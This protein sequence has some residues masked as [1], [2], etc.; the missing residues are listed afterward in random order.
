MFNKIINKISVLLFITTF[1]ASPMLARAQGIRVHGAVVNILYPQM[2]IEDLLV[3]IQVAEE[4]LVADYNGNW[5]D[6]LLPW[7]P[8]YSYKEISVES[9]HENYFQVESIQFT[10][11]QIGQ[12]ENT[13]KLKHRKNL[14]EEKLTEAESLKQ[15]GLFDKAIKLVNQAI[16]LNP[17]PRAYIMKVQLIHKMLRTDVPVPPEL[18]KFGEDVKHDE[19]FQKFSTTFRYDFYL[20]LGSALAYPSHLAENKQIDIVT[21][22][23]DL[24]IG[25]FDE[26][27]ALKSGDARA[28]QGKY[29]VQSWAG[30]Y[31]DMIFTIKQ[32]SE[33]N[34]NITDEKVVKIFLT[35]WITGVEKLTGYPKETEQEYLESLRQKPAYFAEWND[36]LAVLSKYEKFY[37]GGDTPLD[38]RLRRAKSQ[39][40]EFSREI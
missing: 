31:S 39:A 2:A 15:A 21:T 24:T 17:Q 10:P 34:P 3:I 26:A 38:R 22:H 20:Q 13:I 14:A 16:E 9:I 7:G 29:L 12:Y 8:K 5:Y 19:H 4:E 18:L 1:L 23:Y 28:S 40:E 37:R 27:L 35:D 33:Q 11:T 6:K 30:F 36:L 32:F 25:A